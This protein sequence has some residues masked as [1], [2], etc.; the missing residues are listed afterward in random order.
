[1]L[2]TMHR[3]LTRSLLEIEDAARSGAPTEH[4]DRLMCISSQL[5]W[6][7]AVAVEVPGHSGAQLASL[8]AGVQL[9][10]A[11]VAKVLIHMLNSSSS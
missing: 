6:L 11:C 7:L 10:S 1:M 2:R 3:R 5:L 4:T 8:L 9:P